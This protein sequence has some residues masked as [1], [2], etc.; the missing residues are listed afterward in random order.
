MLRDTAHQLP[1]LEIAAG[2][3]TGMRRDRHLHEPWFAVATIVYATID[4]AQVPGAVSGLLRLR[5]RLS[6][7][8]C[9]RNAGVASFLLPK[10][11]VETPAISR[12]FSIAFS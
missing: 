7:I 10:V 11:T 1:Q 4:G 3:G 6:A 8:G 2:A 12:G 5:E 9:Q